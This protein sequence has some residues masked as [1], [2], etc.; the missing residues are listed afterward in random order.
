MMRLSWEEHLQI[1][2]TIAGQIRSDRACFDL[3]S[4]GIIGDLYV[5]KDTYEISDAPADERYF[6][7]ICPN[8]EVT[9][10]LMTELR[11]IVSRYFRIIESM[12]EDSEIDPTKEVVIFSVRKGESRTYNPDTLECDL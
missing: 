9:D 1:R 6:I 7:Y 4:E 11:V 8:V 2:Q 3:L 5:D 10:E 12:V